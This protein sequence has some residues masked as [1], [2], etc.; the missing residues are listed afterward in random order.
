M[1][2]QVD[3]GE[4]TPGETVTPAQLPRL[5]SE[6]SES[7]ECTVNGMRYYTLQPLLRGERIQSCDDKGVLKLKR[8]GVFSLTL[9]LIACAV[10]IVLEVSQTNVT[11]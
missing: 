3:S 1:W 9:T 8:I 11:S 4:V 5:L 7:D 6:Q 10:L 2:R